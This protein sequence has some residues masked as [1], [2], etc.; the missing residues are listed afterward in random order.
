MHV[1]TEADVAA[2]EVAVKAAGAKRAIRLKVS[3]AFH[4][5]IMA[6]ARDGF[7]EAVSDVSFADPKIALFSNVTGRRIA[8]GAEAKSLAVSQIVSPVR[9]IDEEK[10]ILAENPAF[11]AE[12]GRERCSAGSGRRSA[13]MCP[14]TPSAPS[15]K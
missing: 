8:G 3:G 11:C 9:W 2:A 14:A 10:S 13:A 12:T 15:I 6:Y 1:G 4:S 5:P 7:A